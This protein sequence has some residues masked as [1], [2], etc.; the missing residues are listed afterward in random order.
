MTAVVMAVGTV[1]ASAAE[2]VHMLED[3][4]KDLPVSNSKMSLKILGFGIETVKF[5][6]EEG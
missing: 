6:I 4:I 1:A 3:K 5:S 2:G